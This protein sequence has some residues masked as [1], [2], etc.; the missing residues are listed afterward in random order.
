MINLSTRT[1]A[2]FS[3][4]TKDKLLKGS[5][6][7]F[8]RKGFVGVTTSLL[9]SSAK[10]R[11]GTLWYHFKSKKS[12]VESHIELFTANFDLELEIVNKIDLEVLIKQLFSQ[13]YFN[14]DFRYLFRDNLINYFSSDQSLADKL[15][16]LNQI[17]FNKIKEEALLGRDIGIFN[18]KDNE[19]EDLSE[20][21][22]LVAD[23]WFS[24]SSRKYPD[25]D[26]S[27]LIQRGMGL[28]I[29][30]L[31]PHLSQ[32]SKKIVKNIHGGVLL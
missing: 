12:L 21:I 6:E 24:L 11:E 18:F 10:V 22:F 32:E 15:N 7:L 14:W 23:N 16:S 27:F 20:I 31:E 1:D 2:L 9:A 29:R 28:L 19:L 13:Y 30:V 17:R 4:S 25:K 3:G 26:E 8:N 5:L